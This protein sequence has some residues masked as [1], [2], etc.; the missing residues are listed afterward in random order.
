[1]LFRSPLAGLCEDIMIVEIKRME[2]IDFLMKSLQKVW[3]KI[4]VGNL[5]KIFFIRNTPNTI[6]LSLKVFRVMTV[7]V[8]PRK[9]MHFWCFFSPDC[10]CGSAYSKLVLL[11]IRSSASFRTVPRQCTPRHRSR[12]LLRVRRSCSNWAMLSV[13][14]TSMPN[15]VAWFLIRSEIQFDAQVLEFELF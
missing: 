1:M 15:G 9:T 8:F 12:R 5:M 7:M 2:I 4:G 3:L 10:H 11:W 13:H 6:P 14:S